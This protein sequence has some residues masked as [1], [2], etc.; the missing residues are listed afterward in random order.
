MRR[1][2]HRIFAS[3]SKDKE[4]GTLSFD[5]PA[6]PQCLSAGQTVKVGFKAVNLQNLGDQQTYGL[7]RAGDRPRGTDPD[8]HG[9]R[10][11]EDDEAK[12]GSLV[13]AGFAQGRFV[14]FMTL[15]G[16]STQRS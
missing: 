8:D 13:P 1:R 4:S 16:W 5:S 7:G 14:G 9:S 6:V 15:W 2:G 11:F 10:I 3:C 12:T